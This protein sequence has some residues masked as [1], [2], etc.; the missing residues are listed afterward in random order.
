[1]QNACR[2]LHQFIRPFKVENPPK[3]H[4][5]RANICLLPRKAGSNDVQIKSPLEH[6]LNL[7]AQSRDKIEQQQMV[8]GEID[9]GKYTNSPLQ[10][11]EGSPPFFSEP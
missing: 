1:M 8:P 9:S 10:S 3:T 5:E 11:T 4:I 6:P 7:T 2:S